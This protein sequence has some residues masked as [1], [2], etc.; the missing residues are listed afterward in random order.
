MCLLKP[1]PFCIC[2]THL[3]HHTVY[4]SRRKKEIMIEN[5]IKK[6]GRSGEEESWRKGRERTEG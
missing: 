2:S 1:K 5:E 6:V 3:N 4:N